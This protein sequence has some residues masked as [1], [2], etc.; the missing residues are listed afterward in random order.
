[1]TWKPFGR[2]NTTE[3]HAILNNLSWV[4]DDVK[5]S[6]YRRKLAQTRTHTHTHCGCQK[7]T[8]KEPKI[9]IQT[10]SKKSDGRTIRDGGQDEQFIEHQPPVLLTPQMPSNPHH[11]YV[12][13]AIHAIR[14]IYKNVLHLPNSCEWSIYILQHIRALDFSCLCE[15]VS[16]VHQPRTPSILPLYLVWIYSKRSITSNWCCRPVPVAPHSTIIPIEFLSYHLRSFG[17]A[18][19]NMMCT[20]RK[21]WSPFLPFRL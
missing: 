19:M 12:S 4:F 15:F 14:I 11:D 21:M 13:T 8:R 3:P 6:S 10:Y 9:R 16:W 2:A 1:M 7:I 18:C 5:T 17:Y 20:M